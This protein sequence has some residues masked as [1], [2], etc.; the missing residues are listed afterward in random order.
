MQQLAMGRRTLPVARHK[1]SSS[2]IPNAQRQELQRV[3]IQKTFPC[4]LPHKFPVP[5]TTI[6][7]LVK[8]GEKID[9]PTQIAVRT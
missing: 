1:P 4:R 6:F 2:T 3:F 5:W 8:S 9:N 7:G